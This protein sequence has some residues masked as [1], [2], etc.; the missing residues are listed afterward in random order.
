M[1]WLNAFQ[2][3]TKNSHFLLKK[4]KIDSIKL[5]AHFAGS[6]SAEKFETTFSTFSIISNF[7]WQRRSHLVT[8][9]ETKFFGQNRSYSKTI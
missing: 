6:L 3:T 2:T 8:L 7:Q 4:N 5:R 9:F 1:S